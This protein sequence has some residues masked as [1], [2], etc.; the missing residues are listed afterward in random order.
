MQKQLRDRCDGR[1][2]I[3]YGGNDLQKAISR[4]GDELETVKNLGMNHIF[5]S[6]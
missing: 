1:I 4:L 2:N 3:R 5:S 6:G